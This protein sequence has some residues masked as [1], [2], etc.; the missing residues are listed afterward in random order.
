M[1]EQQPYYL[2]EPNFSNLPDENKA[3]EKMKLKLDGEEKKRRFLLPPFF[4]GCAGWGLLLLLLIGGGLWWWS[5]DGDAKNEEKVAV[6]KKSTDATLPTQQAPQIKEKIS[7]QKQNRSSHPVEEHKAVQPLAK[8]N[9]NTLQNV[10]DK[11]TPTIAIN[12]QSSRTGIK[13]TQGRQI[14]KPG[15]KQQRASVRKTIAAKAQEINNDETLSEVLKS[16]SSLQINTTFHL[17]P[18]KEIKDTTTTSDTIVLAPPFIDTLQKRPS[19]PK[20]DKRW[21]LAIGGTLQQQV[22]LGDQQWTPYNYAGRKGT[23][24]DYVPSLDLR[25]YKGQQWFLQSGFRWGAPQYT[26]SFVYNRNPKIDTAGNI[27]GSTSYRLRKTYYH[28]FPI[29]IHYRFRPQWSAGAGAE[30]SKF[31]GAIS[32]REERAQITPTTDSLINKMWVR[33]R[34]DSLFRSSNVQLLL[35]LQ[36]QWKRIAVGVQYLHGLQ[37][38]IEYRDAQGESR[39][40]KNSSLHLFVRYEL[41]R[42]KQ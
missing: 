32:E 18:E 4:A 37:P 23:L 39:K 34:N 2:N 33:D 28:Q 11:S 15:N 1:N 22:P 26:R 25:L 31:F 6:Q 14:T 27:T 3:W 40:Q 13:Q 12:K 36:Y 16:D 35:Q 29:S 10:I 7:N 21:Q 19:L 38:Y 20:K 17:L 24:A 8:E 30:Y 5:I 41:W 9:K 42:Q